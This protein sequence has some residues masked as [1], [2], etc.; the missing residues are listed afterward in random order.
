MLK[1]RT[2]TA[3]TAILAAVL[4]TGG[5]GLP[6]A[7][8]APAGRR[9]AP[10]AGAMTPVGTAPGIPPGARITGPEARSATLPITVA[11]RSADPRGLGRLATEVSIPGSARFRHFLRP[12]LPRSL[13]SGQAIPSARV[14]QQD[15]LTVPVRLGTIM[16][17]D[18]ERQRGAG[19]A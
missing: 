5:T 1:R 8:A 9:G 10:A 18:A 7:G 14:S 13:P 6:S 19:R 12:R 16:A 15:R 2:W 11:L 17:V 3:Y 4:L